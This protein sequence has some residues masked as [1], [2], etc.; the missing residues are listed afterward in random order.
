[1]KLIPYGLHFIRYGS[2]GANVGFTTG[3]F[4]RV[5][6]LPKCGSLKVIKWDTVNE[7]FLLNAVSKEDVE[8][9]RRAAYAFQL[10][11]TLAPFPQAQDMKCWEEITK[12]ISDATLKRYSLSHFHVH[13]TR[14]IQCFIVYVIIIA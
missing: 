4:W 5:E 8:N 10:D 14:I 9:I 7:D 3:F 12:Y 2:T 6:K 11:S 13:I 1:M